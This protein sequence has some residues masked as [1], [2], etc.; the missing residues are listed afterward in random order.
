MN[1][2]IASFNPAANAAF[3]KTDAVS[4]AEAPQNAK[5]AENFTVSHGYAMPEGVPDIDI[6]EATF[7]RNDPLG[8]LVAAAFNLPA[9]E[10]KFPDGD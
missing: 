4:Q 1:L 5:P 3:T 10:M 2:N 6:P 7:D 8:K 9:P